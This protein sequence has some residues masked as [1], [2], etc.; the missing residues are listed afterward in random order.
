MEGIKEG[1]NDSKSKSAG[2][3]SKLGECSRAELASRSADA[4]GRG[5]S[6][7]VSPQGTPESLTAKNPYV[8]MVVESVESRNSLLCLSY[9]FENGDMLVTITKILC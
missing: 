4:N 2:T 7:I 3:T 1:E 6:W 8:E 5:G 9:Q